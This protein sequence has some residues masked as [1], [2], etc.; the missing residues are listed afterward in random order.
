MIAFS[1]DCNHLYAYVVLVL[2]RA[3]AVLKAFTFK[4]QDF[5]LARETGMQAGGVT[6]HGMVSHL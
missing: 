5:N 6:L 4:A 3:K 2:K 1:R